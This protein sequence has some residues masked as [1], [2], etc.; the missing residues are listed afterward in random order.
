M[1]HVPRRTS[2]LAALATY[3]GWRTQAVQKGASF[4]NRYTLFAQIKKVGGE[5]SSERHSSCV[6]TVQTEGL[7]KP[8][9]VPSEQ[10]E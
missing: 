4:H 8:V 5:Q 6:S 1:C 7:Q 10:E 2:N 3:H 9:T